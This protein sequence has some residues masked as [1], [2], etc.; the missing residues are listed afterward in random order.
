MSRKHSRKTFQFLKNIFFYLSIYLLST[1]SYSES[2]SQSKASDRRQKIE[3]ER[4]GRASLNPILSQSLFFLNHYS[5]SIRFFA[6]PVLN[7]SGKVDVPEEGNSSQ[8]QD[9]VLKWNNV[10]VEQLNEWPH[11]VLVCN[12]TWKFVSTLLL[13]F[14]QWSQLRH[15]HEDKDACVDRWRHQ[16]LFNII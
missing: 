16:G 15:F 8:D 11:F 6:R 4:N 14:F 9:T 3:T 7:G 10:E 1:Q 12:D 13:D 5:F 2:L